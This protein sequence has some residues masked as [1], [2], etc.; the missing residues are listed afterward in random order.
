MA[1]PGWYPDPCGDHQHR[2][3]NGTAWTD[4]VAS[5]G[6]QSRAPVTNGALPDQEQV[7]WTHG[8]NQLSTHRVWIHDGTTRADPTE[9]ALWAVADLEL[10]V[11]AGQHAMGTGRLAFKI[12]YPGYVGRTHYVMNGIPAPEQVASLA[13]TWVS[14]NRRRYLA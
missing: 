5:Y 1:L 4:D 2:Y 12:A 7:L 9:F 13:Y 6:H 11:N 8:R 14:R 10:T 3:W